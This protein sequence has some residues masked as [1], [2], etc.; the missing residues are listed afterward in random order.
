MTF[1]IP[2]GTRGARQPRGPVLRLANRLVV[3]RARR[4]RVRLHGA[5]TLVLVTVGARSGKER[6][7]PVSWFPGGDE[8]WLVVASAAGGRCNP[9]WFHNL[10]AHP[11]QVRVE[12]EGRHTPV[13]PEQLHGQD[14]ERAW[15]QISTSASRFAWYQQQ[16][17]RKLPVIRLTPL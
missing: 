15:E 13:V 7:T 11:D 12:L 8:T 14:R 2:T 6:R 10:V 5:P 16:T 17:D 4:R 1:Q 9:G 3:A